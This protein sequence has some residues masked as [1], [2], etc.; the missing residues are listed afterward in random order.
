MCGGNAAGTYLW[1]APWGGLF[2]R[3][4]LSGSWRRKSPAEGRSWCCA[5]PPSGAG[6]RT[7][8][9]RAGPAW[10]PCW[11]FWW[12]ACWYLR[13]R[14][15]CSCYWATL[16][17]FTGF[18]ENYWGVFFF[19]FFFPILWVAEQKNCWF[20]TFAFHSVHLI[21]RKKFDFICPEV[22]FIFFFFFSPPLR[23]NHKV[24]YQEIWAPLQTSGARRRPKWRAVRRIRF[25]SLSHVSVKPGHNL[26]NNEYSPPSSPRCE[27]M[28][29]Q[30]GHVRYSQM[31]IL[32]IVS[33]EAQRRT[34]AHGNTKH[35]ITR[36]PSLHS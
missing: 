33:I 17:D 16:S 8:G 26:Q 5:Q 15:M 9:C 32:L 23:P 10:P 31:Q 29:Q 19:C 2:L 4:T 20:C 28:C 13:R 6:S 27:K 24:L 18:S 35:F 7:P 25:T 22:S 1:W 11:G 3:R 12:Q 36:V 34:G 30:G 21:E 14:G